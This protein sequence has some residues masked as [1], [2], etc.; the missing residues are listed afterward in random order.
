[1]SGEAIDVTN[2][3]FFLKVHKFTVG[4]KENLISNIGNIGMRMQDLGM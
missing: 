4:A 1:M 3:K 2:R